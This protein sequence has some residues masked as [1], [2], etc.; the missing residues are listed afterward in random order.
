VNL[1]GIF[2]PIPTPFAN[3][4][5][6]HRA[7]TANIDR[8]MKTRLAGL[9]ILGSNAEAPLLED[10]E[11]DAILE[12][13]RKGIPSTKTMIAGVGREST[14]ATIAASR[15]AAA[16]GA[17]AVLVRT[18]SY[19]KNVMNTD[20]FVRHYSAVADASPVPVLLYNVTM[21]TGVNLL[22][23][24]AERLARHGNI[25]GMKESSS[26]MA[27]FAETIA[28]TPDDFIVL[29]GS[30]ATL[31]AALAAG[32]S[33]AVLA[34]SG[35]I[36]DICVDLYEMVEKGRHVDA[37]TLQRRIT[38]LAK[39][40]GAQYG[41]AGLKYALDQVGFTGGPTR[42][43]LGSVPPEGQRKI[44]DELVSLTARV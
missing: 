19:Y 43:P 35:V 25:V 10:D 3:D 29:A 21:F 15:R 5:V 6:D 20:A 37:L 44:Q 31:Y 8:W 36:P 26:D 32:A 9:V 40:L 22:P 2:P 28:R 41:I 18:P 11:A 30:G 12:T 42:P 14:A 38:P 1:K 34:L 4:A 16:R 24:A 39:L 23:D 27:Q 17:D 7:L 13:A 33:G